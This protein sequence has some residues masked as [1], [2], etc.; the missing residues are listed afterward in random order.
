MV[1]LCERKGVHKD[2]A[3]AVDLQEAA[4]WYAHA[5]D[6]GHAVSRF[7]VG[8]INEK[9][10]KSPR[11]LKRAREWYRVASLDNV[12]GAKEAMARIDAKLAA[13]PKAAAVYP[14]AGPIVEYKGKKLIGSTYPE[15]A[16]DAFFKWMKWAIDRVGE[17]PAALQAYSKLIKEIRYDPPSKQ[18]RRNSAVTNIVGVYSVGPDDAFPAPII[19]YKDVRWGAPIQYAYSLAGN[20]LRAHN[21]K[22]RLDLERQ[23]KRHE[24][25]AERLSAEKLKAVKDEHWALL[26]AIEKTSHV[27]MDKYECQAMKYEFELM[28]VWEEDPA[29]RDGMARALSNRGCWEK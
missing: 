12:K 6:R 22:R 11:D 3:R 14:P 28:K 27:A 16:N 26:A 10:A 19:I 1:D 23:L 5:G 13:L 24:S 17:L 7:R 15:A 18:R 8:R 9:F 20:G 4:N 25:G 2:V 21:H 29:Q